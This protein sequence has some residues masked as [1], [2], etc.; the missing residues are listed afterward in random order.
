MHVVWVFMVVND[1]IMVTAFCGLQVCLGWMIVKASTW[2]QAGTR[3]HSS[4]HKCELKQYAR[5]RLRE[6]QISLDMPF[7]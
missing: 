4:G 2:C 3:G 7:G 5:N 1:D 6:C